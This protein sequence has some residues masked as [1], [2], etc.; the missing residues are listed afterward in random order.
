MPIVSLCIIYGA[1]GRNF[2][3]GGLMYLIFN[4]RHLVCEFGLAGFHVNRNSFRNVAG[5]TE[6][7]HDTRFVTSGPITFVLAHIKR[8]YLCWPQMTLRF[9][10]MLCL[11][12]YN[13][14][15]SCSLW[16]WNAYLSYV[17]LNSLRSVTNS[18][19]GDCLSLH[20]VCLF[21]L[22][23]VAFIS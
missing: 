21:S 13:N 15:L 23:F 12:R 10:W 2:L 18:S 1:Y 22:Q 9:L 14:I 16:P 7:V 17:V 5:T 4:T 6:V 11:H 3:F 8:K 19:V 20:V